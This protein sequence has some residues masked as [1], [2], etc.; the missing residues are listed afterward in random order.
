MYV[1]R[2]MNALHA[3]MLSGP[4]REFAERKE[5]KGKIKGL[6]DSD[7]LTEYLNR[8]A[9]NRGVNLHILERLPFA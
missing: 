6:V 4:R 1:I 2:A 3:D 8:R 9:F 5:A 7:Q